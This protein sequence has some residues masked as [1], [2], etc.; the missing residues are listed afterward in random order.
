MPET[1]AKPRW[2]T[3][4][5][6][7]VAD[8]VATAYYYRDTLGFQYNM[9]WGEPPCFTITTRNGA[10]VMLSQQGNPGRMLPNSTGDPEDESWDAYFWIDDADTLYKE[11]GDKGV[12]FTQPICDQPYG[13]RDFTIRDCNGYSLGFGQNLL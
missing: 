4:P 3:A 11:F 12:T 8:V 9:F 1:P 6:F 5:C 13:C 7:L 2:S 10:S